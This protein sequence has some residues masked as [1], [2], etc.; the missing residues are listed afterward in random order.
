MNQLPQSKSAL[1]ILLLSF[2]L[3]LVSV[4][5]GE[6]SH[7]VRSPGAT[8]AYRAGNTARASAVAGWQYPVNPY[9]PGSYANRSFY[10]CTN[11]HLGEDEAQPEGTEVRSIGPGTIK[12]YGPAG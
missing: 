3:I 10:C 12:F 9:T 11:P 1:N 2:V 7:P 4:S 8:P 6:A 5:I